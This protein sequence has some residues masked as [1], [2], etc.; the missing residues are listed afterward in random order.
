M[1]SYTVAGVEVT[2]SGRLYKAA[3]VHQPLLLSGPHAVHGLLYCKRGKGTHVTV[4]S[5]WVKIN[6]WLDA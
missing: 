6:T 3:S 4:S 2:A 1:F 5:L